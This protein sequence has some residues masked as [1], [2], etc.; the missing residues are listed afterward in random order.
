MITERN[1]KVKKYVT[2]ILALLLFD[3]T[4]FANN[5]NYA[6]LSFWKNFNDEILIENLLQVYENNNDLKTAVL[7]VNEANRVV[8]MSFANELPHIGFEGYVGRIFKSSDEVFGSITIPNYSETRYYLPL[9]MNY[10]I[11]IWGQNHL[12]T[13]SKKKQLE[14]IKQD[15]R[16]SYIYISSAFAADYFNLIRCDKLI[17]YQLSL[18]ALQE[19]VI[20]SYKTRYEFGTATLSDIDNSKKNLT[21]MKED[22]HKLYEKQDVLKNQMS[23]LLG[24]R[25][26]ENIKRTN[27][28]E[29]DINLQ[30]PEG[31]DFDMLSQR[32]DRIKSELN[33]ERIGID[34]KVAQRD[35]LPK[36]I[37]TGNMGFNMY[38]ISS[39]HKF[40]A[41][42]GIVPVWYIFMG[43]RKIQ[44]LKLK[45]DEY[46]MAVQKYEKVLLTS[47]Q[48]T[49]DALFGI[50]TSENIKNIANERLNT[51]IKE[52]G[53]TQI[54][55]DAGTAD[56]LDLIIQEEKMLLSK[57]MYVSSQIN[58]IISALN[59]YQA[60]GGV[61]FTKNTL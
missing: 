2:L 28:D 22:L 51:D 30:I 46:E 17:E 19:Q 47:I 48:E 41:D 37:I 6:D 36:F 38:N 24:D 55:C 43:G 13:K 10:E 60:L 9:T 32:P 40:L 59:L 44:L 7:K 57:K 4:A 50:K 26:F 21:Y 56:N 53:Y 1:L 45:K 33:L 16:T 34:V 42:L 52:L 31:I 27:F 54:K 20:N 18:I 49:N 12:R 14:M 8:K 35:F 61:D 29:L 23:T 15:E 11:D 58:E 5:L 39:S 25:S 3:G